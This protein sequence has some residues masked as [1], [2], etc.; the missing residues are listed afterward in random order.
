M[1]NKL[2]YS[3][4]QY[5]HSHLLREAVNIGVLFYFPQENKKLHFYCSNPNRLRH[6]YND[7][8]INYY[9]SILKDIEEDTCKYS[10]DLIAR[11]VLESNPFDFIDSFLLKEDDSSLQFTNTITSLYN[12]VNTDLVIN[13]YIKL[14][15]P[16]DDQLE[17][18]KPKKHDEAFIINRFK[19]RLINKNPDLFT[20]ISN[21]NIDINY[22][23][24]NFRFDIAWQNGTCNLVKPVGFDLVEE[25]SIQRKTA[26]YCSYLHWLEPYLANN[27]SRI[28]LL[29]SKPSNKNLH[30]IYSN[31]IKLLNEVNSPKRI[32]EFDGLDDY[33]NEVQKYVIAEANS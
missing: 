20:K 5:K 6:L 19:N 25:Q 26:E 8:D 22:K 27:N 30:K 11:E 13:Q 21:K 33:V 10:N 15:F 29:L 32:I 16:Y 23:S 14:L 18:E 9:K 2:I 4:L 31:S 12:S 7:I 17:E 1:S 3:I 28:D 24:L